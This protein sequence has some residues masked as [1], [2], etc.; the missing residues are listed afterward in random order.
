MLGGIE[1]NENCRFLATSLA[2][3]GELLNIMVPK[4]VLKVALLKRA[5]EANRRCRRMLQYGVASILFHR[6]LM[7]RTCLFTAILAFASNDPRAEWSCRRLERNS[8]WWEL[9]WNTYDD[10]RFKKTFRVSRETY[11][12]IL[13]RIRNNLECET[14][15]EEPISQ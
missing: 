6:R 12:F 4:K 11:N 9:V 10:E 1:V 15:C 7:L 13:E 2:H 8:G 5:I 14:L 3:S